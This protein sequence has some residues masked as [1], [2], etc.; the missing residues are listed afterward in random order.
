MMVQSVSYWRSTWRLF[1]EGLGTLQGHKV[2]IHVKSDAKLVFSKARTLPYAYKAK[3]EQELEV[4]LEPVEFA[5]WA[6]PI[7]AVLKKDA[8]SIQIYGDFKQTLFPIEAIHQRVPLGFN[9]DK[10]PSGHVNP[11]E[12]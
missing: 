9:L 12:V 3:V 2:S 4:I 10:V 1:Q 6:S 5:E 8:S 7:V 11:F